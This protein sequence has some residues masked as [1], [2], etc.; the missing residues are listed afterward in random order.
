MTTPI[1]RFAPSP[2]GRIHIGNAR[3][4][5]FNYLFAAT[6]N[7]RFVL[8]FDD[9]DFA[10]S[11]AAFAQGIEVDLAWL[12]I[13]PQ[14]TLRQS[15]R[16]ALYEAAADKLRAAGRLYP[17]YETQEELEKRRK[18]STGARTAAGLR[19]RRLARLPRGAR[20]MG[21]RGAAPA[22]ALSA[23]IKD[24]T[25]DRP[26]SWRIAHRLRLAVRSGSDPGGWQFSIH[27]ALRRRRH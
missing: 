25:V 11:T 7:G 20:T 21:S 14:L 13:A 9:T 10:R 6:H 4:A 27:P 3:V 16:A 19:P 22:L 1:V 24:D 2:T 26:H 12:G 18:I 5:L 8:R 23:G 17:C 15:D